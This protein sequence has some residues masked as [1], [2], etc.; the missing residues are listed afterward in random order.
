[1]SQV[2]P[3]LKIEARLIDQL[4]EENIYFAIIKKM[5]EHTVQYMDWEKNETGKSWKK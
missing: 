1:M 4:D 3:C 5:P 2:S